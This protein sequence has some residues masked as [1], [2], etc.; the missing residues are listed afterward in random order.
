MKLR[1]RWF[2]HKWRVVQINF[3]QTR[4]YH[5][6]FDAYCKRCNKTVVV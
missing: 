4:D 5:I 2:G 3:R 1:C 6:R